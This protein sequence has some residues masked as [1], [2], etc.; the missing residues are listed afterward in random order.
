MNLTDLKKEPVVLQNA[1]RMDL[2]A[3]LVII[4]DPQTAA[5]HR[6]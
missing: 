5:A 3:D 2:D 4:H 1:M 6:L